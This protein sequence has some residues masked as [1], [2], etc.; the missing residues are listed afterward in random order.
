MDMISIL[1]YYRGNVANRTFLVDPVATKTDYS[2][3]KL[4]FFYK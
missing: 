3:R 2:C 4:I 1:Q